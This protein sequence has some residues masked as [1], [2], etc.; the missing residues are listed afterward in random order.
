[1]FKKVELF[2]SK[3]PIEY[4]TASRFMEKRSSLI[5]SGEANELVWLLEHPNVYTAGSSAK[6][7]ELLDTKDIPVYKT[8]RGGKYTYHG[9]GQRIIYLMLNL[10]RCNKDIRKFIMILERIIIKTFKTFDMDVYPVRDRIGIW[11][12]TSNG[13]EKIGAI[14]LKVKKWI[15]LHG[16]SININPDLQYFDGI[17]PCGL[18]EF[19]VTSI[20]SIKKNISIDDFDQEFLLNFEQE[21]GNV[22]KISNLTLD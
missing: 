12:K 3:T 10:E 4:E 21:F 7:N 5:H 8:P 18:S 16:I 15:S 19:N 20:E 13:E 6:D 14:G 22:Q 2:K 17:V 11:I 9:P 1:M